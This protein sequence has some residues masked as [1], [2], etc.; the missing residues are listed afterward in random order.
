MGN[1]E[2]KNAER[3]HLA[4][5]EAKITTTKEP[6][7]PKK[8]GSYEE[9]VEFAKGIG[10]K[11]QV[12]IDTLSTLEAGTPEHKLLLQQIAENRRMLPK[13]LTKIALADAANEIAIHNEGNPEFYVTRPTDYK[14]SKT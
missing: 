1:T 12:R 7:M 14:H 2:K 3:E 8:F 5:E 6:E 4:E 13:V 11:T 9:L 10:N